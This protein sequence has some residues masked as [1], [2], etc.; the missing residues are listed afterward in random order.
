MNPEDTPQMLS[1]MAT[2]WPRIFQGRGEDD[3]A[4]QARKDLL[5]NYH[6]VVYQY[7]LRTLRD[8]HAAQELHSNFALRLIESDDL[9]RRAD[10]GRGRF[11]DYLKMILHHMVIDYYRKQT[12]ER[13]VQPLSL[14]PEAHDLPDAQDNTFPSVWRQELLNQ[15]WK[16]LEKSDRKSG[17]SFYVLLRL[18]SDHPELKAPQLAEQLGPILGKK[19]TPEAVRQNLHRGREKFAELLLAEVERSLEEP[20]LEELEKELV[21]L[22]LLAVCH[23]A[24]DRRRE[25]R[26]A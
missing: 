1:A 3:Q 6:E 10:P 17:Q 4:L 23:K 24:L 13:R 2:T 12:R 26:K 16:A 20:T 11:R 14:D 18:Q 22:Q 15:A 25:V 19:L 9:I 21:E 8:P 7:F 5:V